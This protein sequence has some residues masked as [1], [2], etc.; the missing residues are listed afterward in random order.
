MYRFDFG[1]YCLANRCVDAWLHRHNTTLFCRGSMQPNRSICRQMLVHIFQLTN[2]DIHFR[3]KPYGFST[4]LYFLA[5]CWYIYVSPN[6]SG[7]AFL[8]KWW[9]MYFLPHGYAFFFLD[10]WW[11]LIIHV[12]L[13]CGYIFSYLVKWWYMYFLPCDYIFAFLAKRWCMYV[14]PCDCIFAFLANWWHM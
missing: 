12:L 7:F 3:S 13:P 14:L 10:K 2:R 9:Y 5:K 4:W 1:V 8:A 11:Y 6:G